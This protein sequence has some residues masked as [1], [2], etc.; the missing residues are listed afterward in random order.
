MCPLAARPPHLLPESVEGGDGLHGLG[1]R[2]LRIQVDVVLAAL[3]WPEPNHA[4]GVELLLTN[5]CLQHILGIII[6]FFGLFTC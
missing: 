3:S 4:P 2:A 1:C 6:D 5:Q